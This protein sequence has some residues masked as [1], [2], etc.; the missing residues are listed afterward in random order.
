MRRESQLA[1]AAWSFPH[2]QKSPVVGCHRGTRSRP[3]RPLWRCE[4]AARHGLSTFAP[5][6]PAGPFQVSYLIQSQEMTSR[7][8]PSPGRDIE[9]RAD[10][11]GTPLAKKQ[12]AIG[13]NGHVLNARIQPPPSSWRA[14]RPA[15]FFSGGPAAPHPS[16]AAS[17]PRAPR[18]P[19]EQVPL[20]FPFPPPSGGPAPN[21]RRL[22]PPAPPARLLRHHL[23]ECRVGSFKGRCRGKPVRVRR[24]PRHCDRGRAVH[25]ATG[26]RSPVGLLP[27]EGER[28]RM[29]REPGDLPPRGTGRKHRFQ[30]REVPCA[31]GF[32]SSLLAFF[33]QLRAVRSSFR[34]S[35]TRW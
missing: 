7:P 23:P 29:I 1:A 9:P 10:D 35:R 14:P 2:R 15:T 34:P 21:P 11:I 12:S 26:V 31:S 30:E 24:G 28:N 8:G 32:S 27:W 18:A 5:A 20:R 25:H 16:S 3:G 33:S 19:R 17:P 22:D 4:S 13:S 6:I